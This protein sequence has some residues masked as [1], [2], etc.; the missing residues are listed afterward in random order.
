MEERRK[1]LKRQLKK[2]IAELQE[3]TPDELIESRIEKYSKMGF[4]DIAP[5][6]PE[7]PEKK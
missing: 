4:Y 6:V 3:L 7:A 5:E 1:L 2:A